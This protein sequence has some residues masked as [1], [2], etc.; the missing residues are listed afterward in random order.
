MMVYG[1]ASY[2]RS[3]FRSGRTMSW[4]TLVHELVRLCV[5]SKKLLT[6]TVTLPFFSS[7]RYR[8]PNGRLP[9]IDSMVTLFW[10]RQMQKTINI[11]WVDPKNNEQWM[12]WCK[13]I[14]RE[15]E[16]TWWR[17]GKLVAAGVPRSRG[18]CVDYDE[19]VIFKQAGLAGFPSTDETLI[20]ES[21]VVEA[22]QL[23]P[24]EEK[25]TERCSTFS[26][27]FQQIGE[28][29]WFWLGVYS[30][31]LPCKKHDLLPGPKRPSGTSHAAASVSS[32]KIVDLAHWNPTSHQER[33]DTDPLEAFW[34]KL[35]MPLA[36]PQFIV[37][38]KH[39]ESCTCRA[40]TIGGA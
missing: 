15:V 29:P 37:D 23:W 18:G 36:R 24:T 12:N 10:S 8:N 26:F 7:N 20:W 28:D 3:L 1:Q 33:L 6:R 5:W 22:S 16:F 32:P 35:E 13:T 27:S 39:T 31:K 9:M 17:R 4:A 30:R 34:R 38:Y 25:L 40:C 2:G 14:Y 21:S 19:F 11:W